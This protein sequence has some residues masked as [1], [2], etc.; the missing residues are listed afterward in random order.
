[1]DKNQA[2]QRLTALEAEAAALR[3]IIEA[4]ER[5]PSLLT[6]AKRFWWLHSLNGRLTVF[7]GMMRHGNPEL[8]NHGNFFQSAEVAR[9]YADAID[10]L[11]LLRHQP[12][13]QECFAGDSP[14]VIRFVHS[15]AVCVDHL[16]AI[17]AIGGIS[18]CFQTASQAKAAICEIGADRLLR[19]FKTLHG[20]YED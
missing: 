7:N 14:F 6:K 10:T 11:L 16:A 17:E 9:A 13:T 4:P 15:E 19:M 1:M 20:I 5:A 18:P 12:G 2:L 8:Y 3:A